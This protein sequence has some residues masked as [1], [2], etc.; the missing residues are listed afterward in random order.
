MIPQSGKSE[1]LFECYPGLIKSN[2]AQVSI[3]HNVDDDDGEDDD[4]DG[5]GDGDD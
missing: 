1:K 5:G 3:D 4:D 2:C